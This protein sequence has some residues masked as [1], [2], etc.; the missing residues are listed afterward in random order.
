MK[1]GFT[2]LI[3]LLLCL[4]GCK[5][6]QT[7]VEVQGEIKGLEN[8]TLYLYGNDELSDFIDTIFVTD[9][10]FSLTMDMD[11][12]VIEAV[13]FINDEEQYPIYLER[14]QTIHIKGDRNTPG[15]LEVKG[16]TLNEE[17]TAFNKTIQDLPNPSDSLLTRIEAYIHQHQKSLVNIYLL[18]K[19]FVQV[20]KPD[21]SKIKELIGVMDG[22]LQDKPYIEKLTRLIEQSEKV[23]IDKSAPSFTITN[24]GGRKVSRTEF[25]DKY[26][27]LTFWASWNDSSKVSNQELKKLYK[28][29]P[30]KKKKENTRLNDK[31]TK[32]PELAIVGISLDLDKASWKEAI[33]QD[34]LKWEQLSDFTGW[35]S[36]VVEQYAVQEIPYNILIDNKGKIIAR[37]IQGEELNRKLEEL[38]KPQNK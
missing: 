3:T 23:E 15:I 35:N 8:D 21:F 18:D 17:L 25:R 6:N 10:H 31:N 5:N 7:Q 26:L 20:P 13:L 32:E 9:G 12:T 36:T 1:Q 38:L 14:G 30:P 27:L 34:T 19:H 22:S 29:Y 11:T 16:S 37:G 4:S 24:A 33:K 2:I 28:A